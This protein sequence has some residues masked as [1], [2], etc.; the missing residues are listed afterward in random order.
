M[1]STG[2][3]AILFSACL[4]SADCGGQEVVEMAD[5]EAGTGEISFTVFPRS[6]RIYVTFDARRK[7]TGEDIP[8]A[9]IN[10]SVE[11]W[12]NKGRRL[13]STPRESTLLIQ[14]YILRYG[15]HE[16]MK[17][18]VDKKPYAYEV[19]GTFDCE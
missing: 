12:D 1:E 2:L 17:V 6:Y 16:T 9:D 5:V 4:I 18:T 15:S 3:K 13:D 11:I 19:I 8:L 10:F 14:K 7:E